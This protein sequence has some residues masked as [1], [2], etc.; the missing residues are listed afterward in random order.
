MARMMAKWGWE[1]ER[2]GLWFMGGKRLIKHGDA[3]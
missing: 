1:V 3:R 2:G